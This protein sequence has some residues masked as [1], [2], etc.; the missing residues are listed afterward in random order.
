[1]WYYVVKDDYLKYMSNDISD[2]NHFRLRNGY[3]VKNIREDKG[4]YIVEVF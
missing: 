3:S 1:M 4:V 2:I